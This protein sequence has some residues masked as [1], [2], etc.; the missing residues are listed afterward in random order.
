MLNIALIHTQ[1]LLRLEIRVNT[2][3]LWEEVGLI[4]EELGCGGR[5]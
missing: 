5:I 3:I 4:G 1:L 2:G